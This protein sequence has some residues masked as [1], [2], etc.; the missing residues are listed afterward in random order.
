MAGTDRLVD[1]LIY[2][3]VVEQVKDYA[4]FVLDPE[5]KEFRSVRED[6]VLP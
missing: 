1:P 3:Y 4:L 5:A 6:Q 2:Q